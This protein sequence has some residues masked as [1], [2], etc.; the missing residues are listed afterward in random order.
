MPIPAELRRQF[1]GPKWRKE[2]RPRILERAGHKCEKCFAP[3]YT[4][5]KRYGGNWLQIKVK[6]GEKPERLWW[7][8]NGWR[9]N[10]PRK[11][12][13]K[14]RTVTIVLQVIHLNHTP[15]DDRD[16]NL[17][18][19]CQWCHLNYDQVQH[20]ETRTTRKDAERP[21]LQVAM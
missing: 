8:D 1:Y 13:D 12:V 16:E 9:A 10:P 6:F 5:V 11:G 4:Q 18:A 15:G 19:F 21:L 17:R 7:A 14:I 2:V 3:N 20:K